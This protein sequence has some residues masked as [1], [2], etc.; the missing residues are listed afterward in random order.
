M[1]IGD[2]RAVRHEGT[3]RITAI[4]SGR[5][6]GVGF[7]AFTRSQAV[8]LGLAG[9]VENLPDGRVEVVAEGHVEDLE[10][11]LVRL[12]TGPTHAEVRGIE[13]EWGEPGGVHGFF[14]Y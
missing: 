14:I 11:L 4:V 1:A 13:V 9:H 2:E 7:R 5:V 12:R 6:H 10:L 3:R 8:D